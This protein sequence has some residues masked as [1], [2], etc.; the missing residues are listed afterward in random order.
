MA[1]TTWGWL[2]GAL[3]VFASSRVANADGL[4]PLEQFAAAPAMSSPTLAPDG[5]HLAYIGY[6][7][8]KAVILVHDF[9]TSSTKPILSGEANGFTVSWCEFKNDERLL[10]GFHGTE[11]QGIR[12]YGT[13]RL[14][15][16][17]IDGSQVKV[18]IQNRNRDREQ[19]QFQDRVLHWLPEDPRHVV[20]QLDEDG[21][22]WPDVYKL[23]VYT[24]SLHM[25]QRQRS[26]VVSWMTDR[27]GVV[28]F[29]YGFQPSDRTGIYTARSG[30]EG[31]WR[32]IEKFDRF[33]DDRFNPLGFGVRPNTLFVMAPQDGR[34][35]VWEFDLEG[36]GDVQLVFA[37]KDVDVD[38]AI[39]WPTDGHLTGFLYETDRPQAFYLDPL[40]QTAELTAQK[41][42]PGRFA[43][44]IASTAD[45]KRLLIAAYSDVKPV[46]YYLLDLAKSSFVTLM[47]S[48]NALEKATLAPMKTVTIPS[49]DLSIPGYLTLPVGKDP[50]N[51]PTV[52]YPHGGPYARDSWGYDPVLQMMVSRGYAVLQVNFRGST[53]YGQ[54]WFEAGLRG[55]GTVIHDDITAG[56]PW[57][58]R[59]GIADPKG[60]CI[61]GWRHGRYAALVGVVKEPDLYRCA[62]SIA[63][64]SDLNDLSYQEGFFYGGRLSA[65]EFIGANR[66]ELKEVSPLQHAD[67]IK[68][69]V[70]LVHGEADYTVLVSHSKAMAKELRR[71]KVPSELV[72]I[73]DGGHSLEREDM[74]L[75]LFQKLDAFLSA[76]L[77][78][79]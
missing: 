30:E 29:G 26:P 17:N 14:V 69:P 37:N 74:R 67:Q 77:G 9:G 50:K 65:R 24:G 20:I 68:V 2:G 51:L 36:S 41:F 62:V 16:L 45:N 54:N 21:D 63:G 57:L 35:A 10:C 15:A 39:T 66:K 5:K 6:V 49:G 55:W 52:I 64:V 31:P 40:A 32:I 38:G 4:I 46:A 44:V 72:L 75:T 19:V 25:V 61:V 70:L 56:A 60:M 78:A 27:S 1:R 8:G 48:N 73:K 7:K 42:L 59:E 53:G 34:D 43:S 76:N 3:L 18:L 28:R 12:P 22:V 58:I 71:N 47:S 33:R 23:D 79:H 11:Y 13:T